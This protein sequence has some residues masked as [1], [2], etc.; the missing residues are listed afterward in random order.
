MRE[1]PDQD[2]G[3]KPCLLVMASTYPRWE[4]DPEPSFTHELSRRLTDRFRVIALAPHAKGAH[5]N[6]T[7]HGVTVVRYRYAPTRFETLVNDGGIL[8][9][10]KAHPWKRLLVPALVF[11]QVIAAWRICRRE[12][13]DVIH[14]HWLVPQGLIAAVLRW[15]PGRKVPFVATSHGSDIHALN[16]RMMSMVKRFVIRQAACA[17]A[18]SSSLRKAMLR[19]GADASKVTVVP[20]GVDL[21]TRFVQDNNATRVPGRILFVGRLVQN[22]GIEKVV[23][24]MPLVLQRVP[25]AHLCIAGSGPLEG[26]LQEQSI[27][28]GL[29]DKVEFLGAV[30]QAQLPALYRSASLFVA[31]FGKSEGLGLV[32]VEAIGCGC[33]VL[34]SRAPAF[35][36]ILGKDALEHSVDPDDLLTLAQSIVSRL[37][38]PTQASTQ[39]TAEQRSRVLRRF[40][41]DH[42]ASM[43]KE[44]LMASIT[45]TR[46]PSGIRGTEH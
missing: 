32:L 39:T 2:S 38:T 20:M 43:Y 28:L 30:P 14:A 46:A 35:A 26:V 1:A 4:G 27:R 25:G 33:Q 45:P 21:T 16:S 36:D 42:V 41:W 24:A 7:L 44:V 13:V 8:A 17:T 9:N 3:R 19:M 10:I 6:E 22:K 29:E 34:T 5:T 18:V 31:P 11:S 12:R 40:S 37:C 23:S 15:I